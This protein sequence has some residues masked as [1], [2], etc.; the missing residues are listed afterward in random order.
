MLVDQ[1]NPNNISTLVFDIQGGS[2]DGSTPTTNIGIGS[3]TRKGPYNNSIYAWS[4][5]YNTT[6]S[7]VSIY[8]TNSSSRNFVANFYVELF[9]GP[10]N[11][12]SSFFS[13]FTS[14]IITDNS[15]YYC[16]NLNS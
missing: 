13:I 5:N 1:T 9:S 16:N 12:T 8:T 3:F 14:A 11:N 2:G 7:T 4:T 6:K 15:D 10:N